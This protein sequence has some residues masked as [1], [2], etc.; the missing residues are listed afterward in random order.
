MSRGIFSAMGLFLAGACAALLGTVGL[1]A[2][3]PSGK[4][5]FEQ[6]FSGK[7]DQGDFK[8]AGAVR[9]G[10]GMAAFKNGGSLALFFTSDN[11]VRITFRIRVL[12]ITPPVG[13]DAHFGF[14]ME[15]GDGYTAFFHS[16]GKG[17]IVLLT[18]NGGKLPAVSGN[19]PVI[20]PGENT[21]W[22]NCEI[23]LDR[24]N[25][26]VMMDRQVVLT[27]PAGLIPLKKFSFYSYNCTYELADFK[28]AEYVPKAV[29]SI[30]PPVFSASF[31]GTADAKDA[32]GNTL[33]PAVSRNIEFVPGVS[34]Q[35][36]SFKGT[37]SHL[38]YNLEKC[39]DDRVGGVMFWVKK[40]N[41]DKGAAV[42]RIGDGGKT[43]Q[44]TASYGN[45]AGG[46]R[47]LNVNVAVKNSKTPLYFMRSMAPA[48]GDWFHAAVTWRP[49]GNAR[50]FVNGLPYPV[51]FKHNRTP[52][53]INADLDNLKELLLGNTDEYAI[54]DLK[55]FKRTLSNKEIYDEYRKVM[56]V[57]MIV[58][59]AIV[60]GEK[61]EPV[62]VQV[63]PGGYYMLPHPVPG[64]PLLKAENV[65]LFLQL[66]D[67]NGK[68]VSR[69]EKTLTAD[70]PLDVEL[71]KV[72]LPSGTYSLVADVEWQGHRFQRTFEISS[73]S[74]PVST[75]QPV[76]TA[77]KKG[78]L[79]FERN[80]SDP[81][82]KDI[83]QSGRTVAKRLNGVPYLEAGP[84]TMDRFATVIPFDKS[85]LGKP[86]LLEL[87][88]PDEKLRNMGLY[89]YKEQAKG[90]TNRDR[91]QS[92]IQAGGEYP[93]SGTMQ[94]ASY[95]FFPGVNNYLLEARTF[96]KDSP[97]A[98]AGVKI[99]EIETPLPRLAIHY[100]EGMKHRRFGHN[101]EDQTFFNNLNADYE[102]D[103]D[104]YPSP[105]AFFNEELM[106]Y[107]AYT[108]QDLFYYPTWR[109]WVG[110]SPVEGHVGNGLYP[111]RPGELSFLFDSFARHNVRY[112]AMLTYYNIPEM[113]N[114][115]C[116]DFDYE[117]AGMVMVDNF[118]NAIRSGKLGKRADFSHPDVRRLFGNHLRETLRRHGANP[119]FGG[120]VFFTDFFGTWD[121]LRNGYGDDTIARFTK[122]TGIQVPF[123]TG[124]ER[125]HF[126]TGEKRDAWLKWRSQ[127]V[128]RFIAGLRALLNEYGKDTELIVSLKQDDKM[129][130]ERG[131][132]VAEIKKIPG[133][134]LSATRYPTAN[135]NA[136]FW[137]R[138]EPETNEQMYDAGRPENGLFK[139]NGALD[140]A[141]VYNVYFES[142]NNSLLPKQFPSYFQDSDPKAHGRFFLKEPAY[143]VGAMDAQ[144]ITVGG[145]PLGSLGRDEETREFTQAYCALPAQPF[146]TAPGITDP[147]VAR[148]LPTKNGTYF[149]VVNML[150]TP[151]KVRLEFDKKGFLG[152]G[153]ESYTDLSTD[154]SLSGH[155]IELK[156]FQLRSFLFPGKD[157]RILNVSLA[158]EPA[159][160]V[161]FYKERIA[162][163]KE[164]VR[165]L[166]KNG[167]D[168]E[169]EEKLIPA[170]EKAFAEK[171]FAETHR[172]CFA[173]R[174]NSLLKKVADVENIKKQH[175]LIRKGI[176]RVNCGAT[177]FYTAPD[178]T[179]FF[180]DQKFDGLYGHAGHDAKTV[181]RNIDG[182]QGTAYPEIFRTEIYDID[183]YK[184][185]VPDGKYNVKLFLKWGYKPGYKEGQNVFSL[186]ADGQ[187]VLHDFDV[188][189]ATG[190]N[191]D[192]AL[193]V[194][195]KE[196]EVKNG[197]LTLDFLYD[198]NKFQEGSMRFLNGIEVN[199]S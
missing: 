98:L 178:G 114:S 181:I 110:F 55:I 94:T 39:F 60:D 90:T 107:F 78:K 74:D 12:A 169:Q 101:D 165:F 84:N 152:F 173:V 23:L 27:I 117:K 144:E 119:G 68:C 174:M 199:H 95:I 69:L 163:L 20:Q 104:K 58:D 189:K 133:V 171:R 15:G 180:P 116:V 149:Y 29:E 80:F 167:I 148:Y 150:Y 137:G 143:L 145:Q 182:I 57:D 183:A 188:Y 142:F 44:F 184:F 111:F 185:K 112:M 102:Y 134:R 70:R 48:P 10:N 157:V 5:L 9:I 151:V 172:L 136:A 158:E 53:F 115:A 147:V 141:I 126:L 25:G 63:A 195:I 154:E 96:A 161:A 106:R 198:K 129:Y 56:P 64:T 26:C 87:A 16:R 54:D 49:D 41:P 30:Q 24:V 105:T 100:P 139:Q 76:K 72:K 175:S 170:I 43:P 92:G 179:F 65:K 21:Q 46:H 108:G 138:P 35:A 123:K 103:K 89:M 191:F 47:G 37:G 51:C 162:G 79:L 32:A 99:Y 34:G 187:M 71:P 120:V 124:P 118:G 135:R 83:V 146:K 2:E 153:T 121:S 186:R 3:E 73:Y 168:V 192:K 40:A 190:G 155:E 177:F 97:A 125:Y 113:E 131:V 166:K 59:R 33:S 75:L 194:E 52:V 160:A 77:L 22:M 31:D 109:Y 91:L 140:A 82:S 6:D 85:V 50:L 18:R 122:D 128:T 156:P 67:K 19:Q 86:V 38:K 81:N 61:S 130:D 4:I 127:Q 164:A 176:F 17:G 42:L 66:L 159:E 8:V 28:V 132:D 14:S 193:V 88:W 93:N 197:M 1:Q 62:A 13:K 36:L 11:P 45:V 7:K 196:I